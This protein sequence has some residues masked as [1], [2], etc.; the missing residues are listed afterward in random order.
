MIKKL[1]IRIRGNK[2]KKISQTQVSIYVEKNL[3][4]E[5]FSASKCFWFLDFK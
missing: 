5:V 4:F 2:I 3:T 1:E